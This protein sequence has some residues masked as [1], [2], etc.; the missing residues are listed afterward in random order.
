MQVYGV[1]NN[2][3]GQ[4]ELGGWTTDLIF[5]PKQKTLAWI[6]AFV[7]N[8]PPA[9]QCQSNGNFISSLFWQKERLNWIDLSGS[10]FWALLCSAIKALLRR[11][12]KTIITKVS[13]CLSPSKQTRKQAKNAA[14][15]KDNNL[16][17]GIG[18]IFWAVQHT[19]SLVYPELHS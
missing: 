9:N 3:A 17:L 13:P 14:L 6:R 4:F 19:L 7:C 16:L 11:T 10:L 5:V 18:D 2:E 8:Y 15:L 1:C 12:I